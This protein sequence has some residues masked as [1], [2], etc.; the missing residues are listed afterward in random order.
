MITDNYGQTEAGCII[1]CN[2]MNL[3][4]FKP[5]VGSATKPLL[6]QDLMFKY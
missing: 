6:F 2:Y 4:T 5:K 3:H 1:S